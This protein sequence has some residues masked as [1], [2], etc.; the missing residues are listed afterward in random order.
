MTETSYIIRLNIRH[1]RELLKL[2]I[3]TEEKRPIVMKLLADAEAQLPI[4]I[5]RENEP[6]RNREPNR[7]SVAA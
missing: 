2:S 5:A 3:M 4:A 7:D 1:Y 6:K